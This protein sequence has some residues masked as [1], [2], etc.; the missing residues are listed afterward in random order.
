MIFADTSLVE[1][2]SF[3]FPNMI[4]EESKIPLKTILEEDDD[5]VS[6][7]RVRDSD[8]FSNQKDH[9]YLLEKE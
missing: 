5:V 4:I 6:H 3:Y 1:E 9:K 7:Q 8:Q 2:N